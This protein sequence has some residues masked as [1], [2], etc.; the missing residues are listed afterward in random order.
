[1]LSEAETE[2]PSS[3]SWALGGT[4]S[5]RLS[6]GDARALGFSQLSPFLP[7][8]V[9]ASAQRDVLPA[10]NREVTATPTQPSVVGQ[11]SSQH[12]DLVVSHT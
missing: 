9:T 8:R 6:S 3:L 12:A 5:F 2:S 11:V 10:C 1:M 4:F 7:V